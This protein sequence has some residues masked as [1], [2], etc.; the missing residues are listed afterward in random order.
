LNCF[1][2]V[3]TAQLLPDVGLDRGGVRILEEAIDSY[4]GV[5]AVEE[6]LREV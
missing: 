6:S 1:E 3:A 5:A 4:D 2:P